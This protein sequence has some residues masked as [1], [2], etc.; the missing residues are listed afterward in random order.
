MKCRDKLCQELL[1]LKNSVC[2]IDA[3]VTKD[4]CHELFIKITP[5]ENISDSDLLLIE[6]KLVS[7]LKGEIAT[8]QHWQMFTYRPAP[9]MPAEY[10]IRFLI[11]DIGLEIYPFYEEAIERIERL[12]D[13][14]LALDIGDRNVIFKL[15]I[16]IFNVTRYNLSD[17]IFITSQFDTS[18]LDILRTKFDS[19]YDTDFCGDISITEFSKL[20]YCP[21]I[22]ISFDE[23]DISVQ[24]DFLI[25][26]KN[27]VVIKTL[28]KWKYR[29][30]E[31]GVFICLED[32]MPVY[33]ALP[34]AD[35]ISDINSTLEQIGQKRILSFVC[36]CL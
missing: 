18:K 24:N 34:E 33:H 14:E 4:V 29:L 36:V 23:L 15:E 17:D 22:K 21:F 30:T 1:H 25:V 11:L 7:P 32:Y 26:M 3:D 9:L 8:T 20:L 28:H 5:S 2:Q 27:A 13:R 10:Y 12:H 6:L 35:T 16:G 31:G 19:P